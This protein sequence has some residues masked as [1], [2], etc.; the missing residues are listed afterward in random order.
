MSVLIALALLL[1]ASF[2]AGLLFFR[3]KNRP[4]RNKTPGAPKKAIS[5]EERSDMIEGMR[6]MA[7]ENPENTAKLLRNWLDEK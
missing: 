1:A 5:P 6:E 3:T 7:K 4:G 2:L